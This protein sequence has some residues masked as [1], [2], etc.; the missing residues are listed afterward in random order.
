MLLALAFL[1][2][3]ELPQFLDVTHHRTGGR[4]LGHPATRVFAKLVDVVVGLARQFV[5]DPP[6]S[7]ENGV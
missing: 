3:E 6:D 1:L 5:F 2:G 7:F 4:M